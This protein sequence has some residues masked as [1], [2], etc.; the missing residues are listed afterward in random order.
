VEAEVGVEV[1]EAEEVV[2]VG[3]E[4]EAEAAVT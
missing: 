3:A 4:S 1:A 2:A